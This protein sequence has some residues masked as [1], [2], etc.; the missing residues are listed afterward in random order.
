MAGR[1]ES[2]RRERGGRLGH[3]TDQAHPRGV[4]AWLNVLSWQLY[5][6]LY[7]GVLLT[8]AALFLEDNISLIG[9]QCLCSYHQTKCQSSSLRSILA[10][11]PGG[12]SIG[13]GGRGC[14]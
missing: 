5:N 14:L 3:C 12:Q 2:G 4:W 1:W 6:F 9:V 7:H 8:R 13:G 10:H 11:R